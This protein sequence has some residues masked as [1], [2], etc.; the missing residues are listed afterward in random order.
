MLSNFISPNACKHTC[1][2]RY[3]IDVDM[4]IQSTIAMEQN[5]NGAFAPTVIIT[6][7]RPSF[8]PLFMQDTALTF[9][10]M[11]CFLLLSVFFLVEWR[12]YKESML[13][14]GKCEKCSFRRVSIMFS[15]LLYAA[16]VIFGIYVYVWSSDLSR[17]L[18]GGYYSADDY[19]SVYLYSLIGRMQFTTDILFAI[20]IIVGSVTALTLNI[21]CRSSPVYYL[22]NVD[23]SHTCLLFAGF[24]YLIVVLFLA[25]LAL[26]AFD[27]NSI[28]DGVMVFTWVLD[29]STKRVFSPEIMSQQ[30]EAGS[31]IGFRYGSYNPGRMN[32]ATLTLFIQIFSWLVHELAVYFLYTLIIGYLTGTMSFSMEVSVRIAK[33]YNEDKKS[34]NSYAGETKC[35][36]INTWVKKK[37]MLLTLKRSEED[38]PLFRLEDGDED[39]T[40]ELLPTSARKGF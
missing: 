28:F 27:L 39:E 3:N 23:H 14:F 18:L 22:K 1:A 12:Y 36:Q 30:P 29:I 13:V 17:S 24:T 38:R 6:P 37:W 8:L 26:G 40:E 4:F 10:M 19:G 7:F 31:T 32:G 20:L 35:E 9:L 25:T 15:L 21:G 16:I 34:Q 2:K 5:E 11:F 33:A